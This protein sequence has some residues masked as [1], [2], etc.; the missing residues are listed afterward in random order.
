MT[1]YK[2]KRNTKLLRDRDVDFNV[3]G[4]NIGPGQVSFSNYIGLVT[5][6]RVSILHE[7]WDKVD[8]AVKDRIWDEIK[9]TK[10]K[11]L[12]IFVSHNT[13]MN[14]LIVSMKSRHQHPVLQMTRT[15]RL[16]LGNATRHGKILREIWL[17][18]M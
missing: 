12:S 15:R 2:K 7:S 18:S 10:S 5:R 8:P 1:L 4:L 6:C 3:Y 16:F 9:V 14:I 17:R 13:T 11:P